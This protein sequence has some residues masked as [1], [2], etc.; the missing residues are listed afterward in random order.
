MMKENTKKQMKNLLFTFLVMIWA[1][2]VSLAL[3]ELLSISDH[4]T[5]V[6]VF[7]VFLISIK[8]DGYFYGIISAFISM[9]AVNF[10]FAFPYFSFNFTIPENVISA[11]IMIIIS[12]ITSTLTTKLKAWEALKAEG[13]REKMRA[14]LLRAVSHDLRTPLTSVYSSSEAILDN[15]DSLSNEQIKKLI[16]GI[17]TDSEWLI[18]MVENLLSV[19]RIDNGNIEIIKT[20]TVLFELIDSVMV[21]F[22][23]R[24]PN[25]ILK[26]QIPEET[27][28][29][30][31]D[32]MLIEQV[33]LNILE[34]AEKHAEGMTELS[35]SV[36]TDKNDAIFE[37]SDNG[38]GISEERMKKLF[39]GYYSDVEENP[40]TKKRN[41]GIGLTVCSTIIKA[42]ESTLTA[43]SKENGGTIFRFALKKEDY[44]D[45]Q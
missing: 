38:C 40:D 31:M 44:D 7:G 8:T 22:Q 25:S 20:P 36:H 32:P 15:Y 1:F 43:E 28:I 17:K 42:H 23:K 10:A 45:Q 27:I 39:A 11:I 5:T 19:T 24:Y 6:F 13:E 35:L 16:S 21:K 37:I 18:R 33:I 9:L 14:N 34:N 29:I 41:A 3:Q 4:I 26:V 30:P 2:F 12:V